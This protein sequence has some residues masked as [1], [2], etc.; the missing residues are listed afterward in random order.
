MKLVYICIMCIKNSILVKLS[1]LDLIIL[2]WA[3]WHYDKKSYEP[4]LD[5]DPINSAYKIPMDEHVFNAIVFALIINIIGV[6]WDYK[7]MKCQNKGRN[8]TTFPVVFL[9]MITLNICSI[10]TF[11]YVAL[12]SSELVISECNIFY[13][14]LIKLVGMEQ[15]EVIFPIGRVLAI[16]YAMLYLAVYFYVFCGI[17]ATKITDGN[18]I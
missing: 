12:T 18:S 3:S 7:N 17:K 6:I 8:I 13:A 11:V 1:L 4:L 2:A 14:P 5:G 15:A 9:Y 16:L 10:A